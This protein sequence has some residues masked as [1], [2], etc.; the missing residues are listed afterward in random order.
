MT[1]SAPLPQLYLARHGETAWTVTGQHTGMTDL[2]LT[3]PGKANARKLGGRL[4]GRGFRQVLTSPLARAVQTGELAGFKEGVV[5]D[6]DLVEWNYG[7]YEGKTTP[8]IRQGRPDWEIFRDG[9]PGGE[10]ADDVAA[11][12]DRVIDRIRALNGDVLLFSHSHF[13]HIFAARWLGL[14]PTAGRC[15]YLGTAA[16]S[17]LGYHHDLDDPVIRLWNDCSHE[18]S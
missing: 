5:T 14:D 9:C 4:Q 2:P 16:L 1:P 8:Q 3:E 6:P 12:A 17:I 15:F 10:T 11:R 18:A 13:L 7:E